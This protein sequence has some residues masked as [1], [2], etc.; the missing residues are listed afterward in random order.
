[1]IDFLS[2]LRDSVCL[3]RH[4]RWVPGQKTLHAFAQA[5]AGLGVHAIWINHGVAGCE[6]KELQLRVLDCSTAYDWNSDGH[7]KLDTPFFYFCSFAMLDAKTSTLPCLL[8][9]TVFR[10][11]RCSWRIVSVYDSWHTYFPRR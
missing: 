2:F 8:V 6:Q 3:N 10:V 4:G 1:M 11:R 5:P 9:Y 7:K